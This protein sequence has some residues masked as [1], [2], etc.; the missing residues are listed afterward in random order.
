M[1]AQSFTMTLG[2]RLS[3][4]SGSSNTGR[5]GTSSNS[6]GS[7]G[8]GRDCSDSSAAAGM[9]SGGSNSAA[10]TSSDAGGQLRSNKPGSISFTSAAE[11]EQQGLW[12]FCLLK[13]QPGFTAALCAE[14]QPDGSEQGADL[15]Q[16]PSLSM[17]QTVPLLQEYVLDS[18]R[19]L[20]A[21]S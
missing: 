7:G 19:C 2:S 20:L 16:P 14:Q 9:P 12:R 8:A 4:G 17:W 6:N 1:A 11:P 18:S 13:P 21:A 10:G 15:W 3:G 5:A